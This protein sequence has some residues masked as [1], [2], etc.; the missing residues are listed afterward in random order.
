MFVNIMRYSKYIYAINMYNLVFMQH[1]TS[2]HLVSFYDRILTE[3]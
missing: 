2:D 1:G 3:G